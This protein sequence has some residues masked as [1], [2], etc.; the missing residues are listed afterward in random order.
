MQRK[1]FGHSERSERMVRS[2]AGDERMPQV[3]H[4]SS[5]ASPTDGMGAAR[6][7]AGS[8]RPD[9]IR[10]GWM[11]AAA[12]VAPARRLEVLLCRC[13]PSHRNLRVLIGHHARHADSAHNLAV[14]NDWHATLK[15]Q[16]VAHESSRKPAPPPATTSC[17]ALL[18]RLKSSAVR[19]L[20]I[21]ISTDP[22]CV[23]SSFCSITSDP[24]V[25]R[26]AVATGQL[27]LFAS[28]SDAAIAFLAASSDMG[29][30]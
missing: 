5:F 26:M 14:H 27:F 22:V 24:V 29:A 8:P 7:P 15:R 11:R 19:A 13:C 16:H 17:R 12:S 23:L 10:R 28:A 18:G 4:A 20:P 3:A 30:P 21:A 6:Q 1:K 25:S 2:P 9:Q